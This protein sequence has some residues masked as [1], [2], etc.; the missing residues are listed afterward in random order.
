MVRLIL[1][2]NVSVQ[3]VWLKAALTWSGLTCDGVVTEKRETAKPKK[4]PRARPIPQV[5]PHGPR[6]RDRGA[7]ESYVLQAHPRSGG[8]TKQP[9]RP[10]AFV[11]RR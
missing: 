7:L 8:G 9:R 2:P 4:Y 3:V 6:Q 5:P 1:L 10:L 11:A